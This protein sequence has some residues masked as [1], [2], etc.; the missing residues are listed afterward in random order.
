MIPTIQIN[1]LNQMQGPTDEVERHFLFVG[2]AT[3]NNG[4]LLSLNTQS[5]LDELL[6]VEDSPLKANLLAAMQNAGQNWS[7]HAHVLALGEEWTEAVL[8]AQRTASFEA[9]VLL[10]PVTTAEQINAAQA[11]RNQLIAT[12][13]RWQFMM[14]AVN[15][16]VAD[17]V[18]AQD[19]P[20]YEATMATLANG[21]AADGV[22]LVPQLHGNNAGVLAGRLCNR[23]VSVA[24][25]PM[26]V[27]TGAL[28]ALGPDPVDS[29]G[30]ELSLATLQ[31]LEAARLSVPWWFPDY[32]GVYWADGNMLDVEGGDYQVV[33]NRR[34]T[35]KIARKLR[36]RA[37]SRIGDRQLNSTP[38]SVAAAKLFFMRDLRAMSK[39]VTIAGMTF[40]GEIMP[41]DDGDIA[42]EWLSKYEVAIYTLAQPYDCPKK[43]GINIILDL[44]NPGDSQ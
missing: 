44:S 8:A 6:G 26:R 1:N 31:T 21:I 34:V 28:V 5:K 41:P 39:S 19:W 37:I 42:I 18:D 35:D 14:L 13:G 9:V 3:K 4:K 20:A 24:D 2:Q 23:A 16:I 40:P 27:K 17:G 12:W 33:E 11:L 38:A 25:T 15:G 10:E 22:M 29:T 36:I 32:D 30:A 43:I 7:A